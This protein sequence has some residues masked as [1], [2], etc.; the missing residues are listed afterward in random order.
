MKKEKI[1]IEELGREY[2]KQAELQ[3][4]FI[5]KCKAEIKK[6]KQLGDADAVRELQS[7]LYKFYEI[8][9]ELLET[10]SQLKNYYKYKGEN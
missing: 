4:Y 6:A 1:S 5:N 8:K 3:Q 2:E 7:N 9:S 10:A